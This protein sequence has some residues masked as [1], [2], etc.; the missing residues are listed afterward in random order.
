MIL[1]SKLDKKRDKKINNEVPVRIFLLSPPP[2]FLGF[3][4]CMTVLLM[5][6][7]FTKFILLTLNDTSFM[8][9]TT[10]DCSVVEGRDFV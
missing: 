10:A 1:L 3:Q 9:L 6:A 2:N 4:C 7:G 5:N 8:Q